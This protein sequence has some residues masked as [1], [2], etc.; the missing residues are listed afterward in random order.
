MHRIPAN[1]ETLADIAEPGESPR[2]GLLL[3]NC[4]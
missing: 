4:V 2:Y 1:L 3:L